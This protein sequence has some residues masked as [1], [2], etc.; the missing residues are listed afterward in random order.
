MFH[1]SLTTRK[2]CNLKTG[3]KERRSWVERENSMAWWN[4]S[5]YLAP[6][7]WRQSWLC[8]GRKVTVKI[9]GDIPKRLYIPRDALSERLCGSPD[10]QIWRCL[11]SQTGVFHGQVVRRKV[12]VLPSCQG[13]ARVVVSR[14]G[15]WG[16]D[17]AS[18]ARA[19]SHATQTQRVRGW[20]RAL[21][22]PWH[23][24]RC[25]V[26][27]GRAVP[28]L[29]SWVPQDGLRCNVPGVRSSIKCLRLNE[30][31]EHGQEK[32]LHVRYCSLSPARAT[33]GCPCLV[34][35]NGF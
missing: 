6:S 7:G 21:V 3:R 33:R 17:S 30:K 28:R 26:R 9:F 34:K 18:P 35:D 14:E 15:Q 27:P 8:N 2:S 4:C 29:G 16:R 12:E 11:N 22:S 10:H 24:G 23:W 5:R 20:P 1:K 25:E 13:A 19:A 31:C 32:H